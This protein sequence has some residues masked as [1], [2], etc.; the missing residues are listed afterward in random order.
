MLPT[1]EKSEIFKKEFDDFKNRIS[2]ISNEKIKEDLTIKLNQLLKEVR[3]LDAQ[4]QEMFVNKQVSV[5]VPEM[6]SKI[7]EIRKYI[8]TKLKNIES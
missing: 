5:F 2:K 4:H 1:I 8:D 7:S 6:R 3:A